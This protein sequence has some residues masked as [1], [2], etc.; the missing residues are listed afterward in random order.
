MLI[1]VLIPV[2]N[3]TNTIV[4]AINS[5]PYREDI[6]IIVADDCS[7][8]DSVLKILNCNRKI[9]L[10]KFSKNHGVGFIRNKLVEYSTGD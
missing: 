4:R 7:T 8:D 10:L 1:S 2:Y 3:R 9:K 6:E 5:I